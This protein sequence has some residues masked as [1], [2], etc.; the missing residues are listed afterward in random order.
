MTLKAT[1][2]KDMV[3]VGDQEKNPDGGGGGEGVG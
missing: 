1:G 2:E 3:K